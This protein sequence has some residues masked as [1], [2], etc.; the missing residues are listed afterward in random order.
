MK[1]HFSAF[2]GINIV[3]IQLCLLLIVKSF[4]KLTVG[5]RLLGMFVILFY[6]R[7]ILIMAVKFILYGHFVVLEGILFDIIFLNL[8][9][10]P[11]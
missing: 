1:L 11:N 10:Q 7:L 8:L 3:L 2:S 9:F 6:V 5:F 4:V